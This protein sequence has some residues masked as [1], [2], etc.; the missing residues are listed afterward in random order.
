M[1]LHLLASFTFLHLGIAHA[2]MAL[3]STSETVV[4][5][6]VAAN[7]LKG[8]NYGSFFFAVLFCCASIGW[9]ELYC[10]VTTSMT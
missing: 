4:E 9:D 8:V 2:S 1:I 7:L 6:N 5:K 3:R 10:T